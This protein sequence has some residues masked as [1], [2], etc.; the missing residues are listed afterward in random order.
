M[1]FTKHIYA[2]YGMNSLNQSW[3]FDK[4]LFQFEVK[5]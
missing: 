4:T 2:T 5:S 1:E 3:M